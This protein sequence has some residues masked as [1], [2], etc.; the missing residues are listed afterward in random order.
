[1]ATSRSIRRDYRSGL[2]SRDEGGR[3]SEHADVAIIG[4][5]VIGCSVAFH[6]ARLGQSRVLLIE[7]ESLPG[8]GST[9]KANGGIRAQFTTEINVAMSLASMAILDS[10]ADEIGEPPLYRKAGYLFLTGDAARLGAMRA[11]AAFQSARGVSVEVL[12]APSVRAKAPYAAGPIL[13]GTFGPRDGFIDP[14]GLTNF[15]LREATRAGVKT[16][17]GAGV[18]AIEKDSSGKFR[19]STAAGEI[20]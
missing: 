3:M 18:T 7:K 6:L 14:G 10:L 13:G 12:D 2:R 15:F 16:L 20:R 1:M 17:Y 11:A 19:L 5:G 9:S 4:A 8:S